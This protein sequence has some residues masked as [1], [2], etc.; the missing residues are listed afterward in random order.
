VRTGLKY[1]P[2]V[3][4]LWTDSQY[5]L[6][7]IIYFLEIL[8]ELYQQNKKSLYRVLLALQESR[9]IADNPRDASAIVS[10]II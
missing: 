9:A 3:C 1:W 8:M 10:P 4:L 7:F 5:N 2:Y 6:Y